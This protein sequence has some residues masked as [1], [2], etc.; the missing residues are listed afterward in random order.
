MRKPRTWHFV[1]VQRLLCREEVSRRSNGGRSGRVAVCCAKE[2]RDAARRGDP[3]VLERFVRRTPR[4][5]RVRS[6]LPRRNLS[7]PGSWALRAGPAKRRLLTLVQFPP[8]AT[9]SF[10]P[11]WKGC[12]RWSHRRPLRQRAGCRR[13]VKTDPGAPCRPGV[14]LRSPLTAARAHARGASVQVGRSWR[15]SG[16]QRFRLFA[17][18]V[19]Q[20]PCRCSL[21]RA[22]E[23]KDAWRAR[24]AATYPSKST[25]APAAAST[26]ILSTKARGILRIFCTRNDLHQARTQDLCDRP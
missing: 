8:R 20:A 19:L 4:R 16:S 6:A 10:L 1:S 24:Q 2:L 25:W 13:Q 14:R 5:R 17:M 22:G 9:D 15:P 21:A 23:G 11:P 18:R 3:S 12:P 26:S 7:S